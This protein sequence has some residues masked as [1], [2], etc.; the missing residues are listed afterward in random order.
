MLCH[1][2]KY[3]K[4]LFIPHDGYNHCNMWPTNAVHYSLP[5]IYFMVSGFVMYMCAVGHAVGGAPMRARTHAHACMHTH[6][7][8]LMYVYAYIS[9]YCKFLC[10]RVLQFYHAYVSAHVTM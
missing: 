3:F 6:A 9:K 8:A 1:L 10:I 5:H 7:C 2:N 4:L